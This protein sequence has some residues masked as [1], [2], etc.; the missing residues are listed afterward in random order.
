MFESEVEGDYRVT[1]LDIG[2]SVDISREVGL[3]FFAVPCYTVAEV[4]E[5]VFGI[6]GSLI[7]GESKTNDRVATIGGCDAV[8]FVRGYGRCIECVAIPDVF[9]AGVDR[10]VV[11]ARGTETEFKHRYSVATVGGEATSSD[12]VDGV[13]NGFVDVAWLEVPF[14]LVAGFNEV[15]YGVNA[16][17]FEREVEV[18]G[19][20]ASVA[21]F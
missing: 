1:A 16:I 9:V 5:I 20:V 21:G 6:G 4:V 11:V 14:V 19:A 13:A 7:D 2:Y 18:G 10:C 3:D 17:G 8:E 15:G 12:A